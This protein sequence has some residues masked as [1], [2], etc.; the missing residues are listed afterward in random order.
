MTKGMKWATWIVTGLVIVPFT[1][2][3]VM[4]LMLVAAAVDGFA[5]MGI[6]QGTIV[7]LGIVELT[8]LVLY[9]I[10]RTVVLGTLLLT[11][12]LGGAV[13]ANIIGRTDFIHALAIGLLVWIG[14]WLRVPAFRTLIPLRQ[15]RA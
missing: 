9:L 5:K 8:C 3:A 14:C 7:P 10:P 1:M 13:L 2:S 4:K 15:E 6:P 12:Y 11:G